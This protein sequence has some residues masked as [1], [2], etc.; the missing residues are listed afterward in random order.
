MRTICTGVGIALMILC[1]ALARAQDTASATVGRPSSGPAVAAA[2]EEAAASFTGTVTDSG[3]GDPIAGA[4]VALVWY[5]PGATTAA[6][7]SALTDAQG[8]L[9]VADI[10]PGTYEVVAMARGYRTY[11]S[12]IAYRFGG[13]APP[14]RPLRLG[15]P[16]LRSSLAAVGALQASFAALAA[17]ALALALTRRFWRRQPEPGE[18]RMSRVFIGIGTAIPDHLSHS[19]VSV[20]LR[21]TYIAHLSLH[22]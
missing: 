16:G 15:R 14:V 7:P 20:P 4:T 10:E 17:M 11:A 22:R 6:Q 21:C 18:G 8:A 13:E 12:L 5:G 1:A 2:P 3:S 9:V 19:Q